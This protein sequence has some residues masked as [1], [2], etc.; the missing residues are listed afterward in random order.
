MEAA[1]NALLQPAWGVSAPGK[2]KNGSGGPSGREAVHLW[3]LKAA[4]FAVLLAHRR[5]RQNTSRG[6][7]FTALNQKDL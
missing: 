4:R 6:H 1:L 5:H 3:C 2:N 7:I